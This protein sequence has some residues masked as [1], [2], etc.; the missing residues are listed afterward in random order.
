MSVPKIANAM[1]FIDDELISKAESYK[2]KSNLVIT[3]IKVAAVTFAACLIL[4]IIFYPE[5]KP[6]F[7]ITFT[8]TTSGNAEVLYAHEIYDHNVFGKYFPTVFAENYFINGKI[9]IYDNTLEAE[10]Y[11]HFNLDT[12]Y[13]HIFPKNYLPEDEVMGVVLYPEDKNSDITS[14]VWVDMGEYAAKFSS[15]KC[16]LATLEGFDKMIESMK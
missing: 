5:P 13:L 8:S 15:E 12:I 6:D 1:S 9:Y 4:A 14:Y 10:F 2:P 16:D 3:C 11:N 7:P